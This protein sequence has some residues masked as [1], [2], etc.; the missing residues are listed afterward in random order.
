MWNEFGLM[1]ISY[2]TY[3]STEILRLCKTWT[4]DIRIQSSAD[5]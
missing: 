4:L 1:Y 3:D 2:V 5:V